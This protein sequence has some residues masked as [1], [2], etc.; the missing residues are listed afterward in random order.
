MSKALTPPVVEHSKTAV[1]QQQAV[2]EQM[3]TS[4]KVPTEKVPTTPATIYQNGINNF[5]KFI[6]HEFKSSSV[7]ERTSYQCEFMGTIVQMLSMDSSEVSKVLDHF[8]VTILENP[9]QFSQSEVFAPLYMV[10]KEKMKS[11]D[12]LLRY[13]QFMTFMI[14]LAKNAQNRKRFVANV[15]MRKLLSYFPKE[16]ADN[17]QEYC[18]R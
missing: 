11:A 2:V 18:F 3:D 16:A 15:D 6:K 8:V 7:Q 10:E 1:A 17:L 14:N 13:K 12:E 4:T 9:V 5:V